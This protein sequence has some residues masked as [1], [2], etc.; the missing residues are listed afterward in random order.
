M[1]KFNEE[2]RYSPNWIELQTLWMEKYFFG[3]PA[4]R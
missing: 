3:V 4:E 2:K 1:N